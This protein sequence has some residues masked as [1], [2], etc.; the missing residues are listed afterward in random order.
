MK[1]KVWGL[2]LLVFFVCCAVVVKVV[3]DMKA[4]TKEVFYSGEYKL[5]A[6]LIDFS[7]LIPRAFPEFN[8]MEFDVVY[9]EASGFNVRHHLDADRGEGLVEFFQ[10][11][12]DVS[13]HYYWMDFKNLSVLNQEAARAEL[14]RVF[15][16]LNIWDKVIVE[17][18]EAECLDF[19]AQEKIKTSYWIPHFEFD[20]NEN[21]VTNKA[22]R[23]IRSNLNKYHINAISASYEMA[24]YLVKNFSDCSIHLWTNGLKTEEDKEVIR[25]LNKER[26]IKVILVDYNEDFLKRKDSKFVLE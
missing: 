9:E 16:E 5:W 11:V 17:S 13:N 12:P 6:H 14:I 10:K 18:Q 20:L 7:V 19:L 25:E 8:G 1:R 26:S 24:P 21:P 3:I 15:D 4:T 22:V 2:T 23:E